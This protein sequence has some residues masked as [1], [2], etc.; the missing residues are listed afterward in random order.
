VWDG[1]A[2]TY[3]EL[4]RRASAAARRLAA[5]GVMPGDRI[6]T[7]MP[8]G[9]RFAVALLGGFKRGVTVAPLDPLLGPTATSGS[10]DES[11]SG[12]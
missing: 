9:W 8:N 12:S 3:A 4:D 11:G 1:G 10:R 2:L 5:R 7:V 6:A